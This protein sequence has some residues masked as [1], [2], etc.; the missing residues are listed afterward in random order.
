MKTQAE[1]ETKTIDNAMKTQVKTTDKPGKNKLN[2][3]QNMERQ[4]KP[5]DTTTKKE[6]LKQ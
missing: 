6:K 4:A 5:I 3:R 1:N 2:S